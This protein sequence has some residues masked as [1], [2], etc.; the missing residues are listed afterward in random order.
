M[1]LLKRL[2]GRRELPGEAMAPLYAAVVAR[3]RDPSWYLQG[4]VPDTFD[5]RFD[6]LAAILSLVLIRLE[7]DAA[8]GRARAALLTES[9]I[10]DMDGQ[11][12]ERGVGDLIVGK[13][14]GRTVAALGGRLAAYRAGI[15][16]RDALADALRRNLYRG[17]P[18]GP[19]AVSWTAARLR[20]FHDRLATR[21][22]AALMEGRL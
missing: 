9:F 3:A 18:P 15:E 12:R 2:L 5:G 8:T 22:D 6:M 19:E 10:A 21:D 1:S 11:L 13:H 14:V 16:D 7:R 20:D 17:A 4:G